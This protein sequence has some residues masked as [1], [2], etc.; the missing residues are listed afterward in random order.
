[1]TPRRL[2]LVALVAI[3]FVALVLSPLVLRLL[4]SGPSVDAFGPG[5]PITFWP[6]PAFALTTSE[7]APLTNADLE[8]LFWVATFGFTN[9]PGICPAMTAEMRRLH[10]HYR[11]EDRVRFLFIS[12][13]PETD[14]PAVL[15]A[16]AEQYQADT[17]RWHFLTGDAA[18]IQ[19]LSAEGFKVGSVENPI[20]H[21]SRFILVG[22]DGMILG[23]H[24]SLD[25]EQMREL[26]TTLDAALAAA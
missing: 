20:N 13:D 8:G 9:C 18:H 7:D 15:T 21:S 26:T 23:F 25:P 22:P 24:D 2:T 16:Y 4:D 14:T 5:D 12:V 17:E 11:D 1:M 6:A 3:V 10:E 19:A